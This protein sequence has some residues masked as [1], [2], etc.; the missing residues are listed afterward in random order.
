MRRMFPVPRPV[1]RKRT[2]GRYAASERPVS[3]PPWPPRHVRRPAAPPGAPPGRPPG[4]QTH[5]WP[6]DDLPLRAN[7]ANWPAPPPSLRSGPIRWDTAASASPA[8][9]RRPPEH[10]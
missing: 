2:A 4:G 7:D 1:R 10:A 8:V 3:P 6:L 5:R 9:R